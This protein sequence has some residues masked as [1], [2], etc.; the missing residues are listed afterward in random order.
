MTGHLWD[1][2]TGNCCQSIS[3][4]IPSTWVAFTFLPNSRYIMLT[5]IYYP[6]I[7]IWDVSTGLCHLTAFI[8]DKP[9]YSFSPD[10]RYIASIG[11]NFVPIWDMNRGQHQYRQACKSCG[12]VPADTT[13][14]HHPPWDLLLP[15]QP[16]Y[17]NNEP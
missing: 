16:M 12:P 13:Y 9:A 14:Q 2:S 10:G 17:S 6:G 8:K 1:S 4:D 3:I 7:K 15:R 11:D 5:S